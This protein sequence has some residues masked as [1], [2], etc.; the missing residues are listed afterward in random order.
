M[1]KSNFISFGVFAVMMISLIAFFLISPFLMK[2]SQAGIISPLACGDNSPEEQETALLARRSP[3]LTEALKSYESWWKFLLS[4]E[5]DYSDRRAAALQGQQLFPIQNL[6]LLMEIRR[7]LKA[8]QERSNWGLPMAPCVQYHWAYQMPSSFELLGVVWNPPAKIDKYPTTL[9]LKR[10]APWPWQ[11][12][13][14]LEDLFWKLRRK[15]Y[16]TDNLN[17]EE[18]LEAILKM[19]C[20]TDRQAMDIVEAISPAIKADPTTTIAILRNIAFNPKFPG[21]AADISY[22]L[23]DYARPKCN[24]NSFD[25]ERYV[26]DPKLV[27]A[28]VYDIFK[29]S[30]HERA[31]EAAGRHIIGYV[32]MRADFDNEG[33]CAEFTS[34]FPHM[35]KIVL[36]QQALKE[37]Y[38]RYAFAVSRIV[39]HPPFELGD[40]WDDLAIMKQNSP[41][42][43][44][45]YL[46]KFK[47]WSDGNSEV[48]YRNAQAE[49]AEIE[50]I[51]E[52]LDK[53]TICAE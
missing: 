27:Y 10:K 53:V 19:P 46:K 44:D 25:E 7:K 12:S 14:A 6:P 1:G 21:A 29:N 41:Q 42:E 11:V 9:E 40:K 50:K 30:P 23:G 28:V 2:G 16:P 51:K 3:A 32:K 52:Q 37:R 31:R 17:S 33:G 39:D 48:L 34:P 36:I 38:L 20:E 5:T 35:E 18:W 4:P 24:G 49:A 13:I 43:R 45:G 8:E 47:D 26:V 15:W 22:S